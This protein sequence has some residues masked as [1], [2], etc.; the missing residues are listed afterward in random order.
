MTVWHLES[1]WLI[2]CMIWAQMCVWSCFS[3]MAVRKSCEESPWDKGVPIAVKEEHCLTLWSE[4]S[5]GKVFGVIKQYIRS[6]EVGIISFSREEYKS[7][8]LSMVLVPPSAAQN[9]APSR[10]LLFPQLSSGSLSALGF[11]VL[12]SPFGQISCFS[13]S[14]FFLPGISFLEDIAAGLTSNG[15]N[16]S[17]LVSLE[18]VKIW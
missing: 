13:L 9:S 4:A 16:T 1:L 17:N 2:K 6:Q 18:C 12:S 10:T 11:W 8:I 7:F 3:A 14:T 5:F 15:G